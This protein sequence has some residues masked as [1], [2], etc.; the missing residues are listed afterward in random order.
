M[1]NFSNSTSGF[2][3][4]FST[5]GTATIDYTAGTNSSAGI[6]WTGGAASPNSNEW[7]QA[8]NWGGCSTPACGKDATIAAFANQPILTTGT[9]Y[10][11]NITIQPG[12]SLTLQAGVTLEVCGNFVNYGT[13]N[14]HPTSTIK[15][16]G[17]AN[18]TMIGNLVGANRLGN[19]TIQKGAASGTVTLMNDIEIGGN[20]ITVNSTS[21]FNS[22]QK[23]VSVAGNFYNNNGNTTYTN[24]G[25][26]GTLEFNGAGLQ[27]YH[28]GSSQLDLNNVIVNNTAAIGSGVT[29][30]TDM[31]IKAATGT[32]T[33]NVGTITTTGT[34][35]TTGFKVHVLNTAPAAV[36]TGNTNSFVDGNL[37][38][39]LAATG[40]YNWPVGNVA[41][42]FQ[43]ALT[44][45]TAGGN[46]HNFIDARF[47]VWPFSPPPT[48][49]G[50]D[51]ATTFSLEAMDNG[52]W[53]LTANLVGAS[54][55]N[56]SLF[57]TNVTNIYSGWTIM[58][59]PVIGPMPGWIL[60]GTC[61]ASTS[62]QVNRN[63][64]SGFSVFGIAQ[65]PTPLPIELLYFDGEMVGEDNLLT[66]ATASEQNND[67]FT[68]E[69]SRNGI[70][71]EVLAVVPGAGTSTTTLH[72]DQ[73]DY[74]PYAGTTY[75]RLKQ[76]D[77]DGQYTYSQTITL[78]RRME[79]AEVSDLFPNP[80]NSTVNFELN[81]PKSGKVQVELFDNAGRLIASSDY[82]AHVGSN[83]FQ[84]DISQLARGVYSTVI[85]F[86]HLE[87]TEIKQLIKQ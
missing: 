77:F 43:R 10:T 81:T 71:F 67:F 7:T 9:Y 61:V 6:I 24:T 1:S 30:A 60:D 52:Y 2:R 18:Q 63:G 87:N 69:R 84:L 74:D 57:P 12:A 20:F 33:L 53:T 50:S 13:I 82:D 41:K 31:F 25:T 58:K 83:N 15:M 28:Q 42:K 64:L 85:R 65:A 70:D 29:L 68:L 47:D 8:A 4:E 27:T 37:R 35:T 36:S 23:Y 49:G 54:T 3:I 62:A 22:N 59:K 56:M 14:A 55:Y 66:W 38:R 51:C 40:A 16:V 78:N 11:R 46:T 32:L 86:E 45:F 72:Y 79:Q 80:A 39:Y 21:I 75:Y 73:F 19:L 34:S 76:T 26:T 48:Q 17:G 5:T 44:N